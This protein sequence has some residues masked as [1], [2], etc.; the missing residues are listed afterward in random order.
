MSVSTKDKD[1]IWYP[2]SKGKREDIVS[3]NSAKGSYIYEEDGTAYLD[4]VSSWWT[5]LHGHCHPFIVQSICEQASKLDHVI[6]SGFSHA[7]AKQL[8]EELRKDLPSQLSKFFFSDDGSTSVEI[9]LKMAYQYWFNQDKK[10]KLIF[11]NFE[12][13]YH[14]DT[15][16][17]MS[18][19]NTSGYHDIF[20]EFFFKTLTIPCPTT[21]DGDENIEEREKH[22]L[23]VLRS[24]LEEF[25][26]HIG[27]L[28]VEPL[29]Q[30]AVGM[31]I[32]RPEFLSTVVS[33]V[34]EY[35]ILVIFDEV[36]TGFFR[37]GTCFAL[38]QLSVVPDILCLGKG[39]TGGCLPLGLTIVT[40]ELYECFASKKHRYTFSHGHTFT[41]NPII[42]AAAV[43]SMQLL[44][45]EETR[46]SVENIHAV[47]KEGMALLKQCSSVR[48]P[49]VLGAMSAFELEHESYCI[50]SFR[51][52]CLQEGL[53][54]RPLQNT[55]NFIPP[56]SISPEELYN[57]Y[58]TVGVLLNKHYS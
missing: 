28:I 27:T 53:L 3:I 7:P 8:C 25:G 17:A 43:A 57:A 55:V 23:S 1:L 18:V 9:A 24:Y 41:G 51:K 19:G 46:R 45:R 5:T 2:F 4:L 30:A 14:G 10:D 32:H 6:F 49:R 22:A 39:I 15:F 29:F 31:R 50:L 38:D 44:H 48:R 37:T 13:G 56:Y 20:S 42:C 12:G 16:G 47:H 11:L 52:L 34:R 33:M 40:E 26:E 21:W 35:N 54:L 58:Q 36:M